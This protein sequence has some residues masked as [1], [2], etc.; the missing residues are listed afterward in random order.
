MLEISLEIILGVFIFFGA[1]G[2]VSGWFSPGDNRIRKLAIYL[3]AVV[4]VAFITLIVVGLT[5][6][7][8]LTIVALNV[9]GVAI[10]MAVDALVH[11]VKRI[12][13]RG[14]RSPDLS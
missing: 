14:H 7:E 12:K 11:W 9:A 13:S 4:A 8:A 2:A 10:F 1:A 6:S 5:F 3:V